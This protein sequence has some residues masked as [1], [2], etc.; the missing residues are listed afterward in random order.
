[1]TEKIT[2]EEVLGLFGG[3]IPM[4]ALVILHN[5]SPDTTVGEVRAEISALAHSWST[6]KLSKRAR[7][8]ALPAYTSHGWPAR[9]GNMRPTLDGET[10]WVARD[11][12]LA[13]MDAPE[14]R[15]HLR[16]RIAHAM[17][18][19][20]ALRAAP[21]VAKGRTQQ[22]FSEAEPK[23][24]DEWLGYADAALAAMDEPDPGLRGC[25]PSTAII[26]EAPS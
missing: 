16:E 9:H 1:M 24:R 22:A 13:I 17:W 19:Q 2:F 18:H 6:R 8:E 3:T 11:A 25:N 23:M 26:D 14:D 21:N 15:R 20:Q 5:A 10:E 12:V 4:E 7:I